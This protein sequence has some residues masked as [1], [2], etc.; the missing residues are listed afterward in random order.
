MEKDTTKALRIAGFS[1]VFL[2]ALAVADFYFC[3][4]AYAVTAV[5]DNRYADYRTTSVAWAVMAFTNILISFLAG[6]DNV[7]M[8]EIPNSD[9]VYKHTHTLVLT[10]YIFLNMCS[11]ATLTHFWINGYCFGV[12]VGSFILWGLSLIWTSVV[13]GRISRKRKPNSKYGD[14]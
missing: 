7:A 3:D 9:K 12:G 1:L 13:F 5:L 10:S 8:R 4:R 2:F 14:E 11:F 6:F